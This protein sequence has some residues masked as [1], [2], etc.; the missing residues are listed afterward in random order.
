MLKS[1]LGWMTNDTV[2]PSLHPQR[3]F[4]IL[5][6][7]SPTLRNIYP[8]KHYFYSTTLF[9]I[10]VF[11]L[12]NNLKGRDWCFCQCFESE[13][14][15]LYK[16]F[17]DKGTEQ[18]Q[19]STIHLKKM[20]FKTVFQLEDYLPIKTRKANNSMGTAKLCTRINQKVQGKPVLVWEEGMVLIH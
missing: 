6:A 8:N 1:V 15:K 13:V 12:L 9:I 14:D 20:A 11:S 19:L 4:F 17:E 3:L 2:T 5:W 10:K 7:H 16:A 18:K